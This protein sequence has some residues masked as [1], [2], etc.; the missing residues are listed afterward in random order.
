[1][2]CAC[3]E[4]RKQRKCR[5]IWGR[6]SNCGSESASKNPDLQPQDNKVSKNK[7][8]E[9]EDNNV[10]TST[11]MVTR[12]LWSSVKQPHGTRQMSTLDRSHR[13]KNEGNKQST[14]AF[15][16]KTGS[17]R[18]ETRSQG[19]S[20]GLK[21]SCP[22]TPGVHWGVAKRNVKP[23]KPRSDQC[24]P[25]SQKSISAT[26]RSLSSVS[27]QGASRQAPGPRL[28][29]GLSLLHPGQKRNFLLSCLLVCFFSFPN[30]SFMSTT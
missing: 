30:I 14:M 1:M 3:S 19:T 27:C 28:R 16:Y 6:L 17:L 23:R 10:S 13:A 21:R 11:L 26:S 8:G 20:S 7:D 5:L 24:H 9:Q 29:P 2:S 22:R 25:P 15:F 12:C 18:P 4:S